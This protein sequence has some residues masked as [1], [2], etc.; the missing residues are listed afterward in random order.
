M[1]INRH[2]NPGE[3]VVFSTRTHP[4]AIALPVVIAVV[5]VALA[6]V[7]SY[8]IHN[9]YAVLAVWVVAALL[10][11]WFAAWPILEW[12]NATY[13]VTDRRVLTRTGV[14]N[15]RGHD[16][17]LNRISDVSYEKGIFDRIL[18]C[19]TLWISDSSREGRVALPDVP[20]VEQRQLQI[21][22][23]LFHG[24]NS[25]KSPDGDH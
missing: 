19:G 2:L 3:S 11:L 24:S 23:L 5:V 21:S 17:P 1:A 22:D 13:T 4:K 20:H 9:G 25:A 16:I 14:L 6:S 15:G 10:I 8:Y 7:G 18:G 12:M